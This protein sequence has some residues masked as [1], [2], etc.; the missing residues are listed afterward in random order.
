MYWSL[1]MTKDKILTLLAKSIIAVACI[2][3]VIMIS[4]AFVML[5]VATIGISFAVALGWAALYLD[6]KEETNDQRTNH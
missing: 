2:L 6:S 4:I 1:V 5:P 3:C